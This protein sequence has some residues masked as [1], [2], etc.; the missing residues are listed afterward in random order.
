M[1]GGGGRA[2]PLRIQSFFSSAGAKELSGYL[3]E[4]QGDGH[5][6]E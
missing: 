3:K 2:H 6:W 1:K 4:L 5:D